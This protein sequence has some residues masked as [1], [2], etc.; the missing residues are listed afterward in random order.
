MLLLDAVHC[1]ARLI[2]DRDPQTLI[3]V[4]IDRRYGSSI[5]IPRFIVPLQIF[6]HFDFDPICQL[7]IVFNNINQDITSSSTSSKQ[8]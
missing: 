7:S 1:M 5:E 2:E 3:L 6:R 4:E 8:L